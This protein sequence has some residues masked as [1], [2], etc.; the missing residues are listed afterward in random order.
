MY[1]PFIKHDLTETGAQ[2]LRVTLI[3]HIS[4]VWEQ[5]WA[6]QSFCTSAPSVKAA[7]KSR[8]LLICCTGPDVGTLCIP[9]E[10]LS[11]LGVACV[12][13]EHTLVILPAHF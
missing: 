3:F 9:T 4:D 1:K 12:A 8:P 11:R 6:L 7:S 13:Q 2:T 10:R 5:Q